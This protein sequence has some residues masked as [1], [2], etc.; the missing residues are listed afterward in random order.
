[1]G[2][3][4]AL[5]FEIQELPDI[6]RV[7]VLISLNKGA[8]LQ[9]PLLK[10]KVDR[11]CAGFVC[12]ETE[13][14]DKTL[15][16]MASEGLILDEDGTVQLTEQGA[17]L[18]KEW[19][20]LL[21]RKEP[22]IEVVAGLV[23]GSITGLVVILS[24]FIAGLTVKAAAFAA[25]LT[26]SSVAITNFSSFLL[27]GIT[28]DLADMMTLQTLMNYSLSDIPDRLE[29][30]KS[31]ILVKHL[32]TVLQKDI[33]R[34]NLLAALI[35]G[36]TSFM[37]GIIP[38]TVYFFLPKPLNFI[39]SLAIVAIATGFFLVRYRS[40]K[41]KVHWKITLLETAV[42]VAIAVIASLLI[43]GTA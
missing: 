10:H 41:S 6:I 37:A 15:V 43:G 8:K 12:V 1:M 9:K 27:G 40:R 2:K 23:D 39:L 7:I 16:E 5:S 20:S 3:K 32:F 22:I 24:A 14:L 42:I 4:A 21:L 19:Q 33:N 38:I 31:L 13:D 28:E 34:S 25:F 30:D 18:G 11:V 26:L 35:C 36:T 29:R 17:K